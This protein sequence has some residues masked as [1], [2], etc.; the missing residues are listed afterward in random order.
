MWF[1][2]SSGDNWWGTHRAHTLRNPNFSVTIWEI[3]ICERESPKSSFFIVSSSCNVKRRSSLTS[4]RIVLTDLSITTFGLLV[5]DSS[6]TS[7]R[8]SR[9][10]WHHFFNTCTLIISLPYT[11]VCCLWISTVLVFFTDKTVSLHEV[12][13]R[14]RMWWWTL[15]EV[16][17]ASVE[18]CRAKCRACRDGYTL[19]HFQILMNSV[20]VTRLFHGTGTPGTVM[21]TA[22]DA[23]YR[24]LVPRCRSRVQ[25]WILQR[26]QGASAECC[27]VEGRA[28][29][30]GCTLSHFQILMNSAAVTRLFHS[31][32]AAGT[33]MDP[34]EGAGCRCIIQRCREPCVQQWILQIVQGASAECCRE[35]AARA[36]KNPR[37]RIY[38][39]WTSSR[40]DPHFSHLKCTGLARE[41]SDL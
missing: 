15:Q 27:R 1:I 29:S 31:T 10:S 6:C 5:C 23:G 37:S 22:E 28:C 40:K 3:G 39:T 34:A 20:A 18:C 12:H 19:S 14:T 35:S 25:Q 30:D 41:F 4:V 21:D 26:V 36:A 7:C 9:N 16:Q 13:T 32:D 24:Y 11:P 33:A 17:R 38:K 8:P 2:L